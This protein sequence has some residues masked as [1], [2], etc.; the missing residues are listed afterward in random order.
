MKPGRM[1]LTLGSLMIV[2]AILAVGLA[3]PQIGQMLLGSATS[4]ALIV[5]P[6]FLYHLI[7][8]PHPPT[9]PEP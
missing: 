3:N 7:M 4:F 1:Q 5:V 8:R 9:P 6:A 2:I